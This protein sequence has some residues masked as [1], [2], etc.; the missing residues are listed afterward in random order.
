VARRVLR[1]NHDRHRVKQQ[2]LYGGILQNHAAANARGL[3]LQNVPLLARQS[4]LELTLPLRAWL[5]TD[6]HR[7]RSH[8]DLRL[9]G[10]CQRSNPHRSATL[11]IGISTSPRFPPWGLVQHLPPSLTGLGRL[12]AHRQLSDNP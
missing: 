5:A 1:S 12:G 3:V 4:F 6:T 2:T 9:T 8:D 11:L 10:F 7:S